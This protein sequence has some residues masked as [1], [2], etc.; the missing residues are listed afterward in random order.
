MKLKELRK[1]SKT[2]RTILIGLF[3]ISFSI[4]VVMVTG[5]I[6]F[7]NDMLNAIQ[8]IIFETFS[9]TMLGVAAVVFNMFK[10]MN[11]DVQTRLNK[12]LKHLRKKKH[13]RA[14]AIAEEKARIAKK[15]T[16]DMLAAV[17][18]TGHAVPNL[19]I[20]NQRPFRKRA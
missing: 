2:V 10:D 6:L 13:E 9:T 7:Q 8:F 17:A 16:Q 14:K 4:A 12:T 1:L 19:Q 18:D 3:A 15:N 11:I 20:V 5:I